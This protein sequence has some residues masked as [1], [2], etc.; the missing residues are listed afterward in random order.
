M[1]TL[2]TTPV[3]YLL[4]DRLH[5]RL[6]GRKKAAAAAATA[7]RR[8]SPP[9]KRCRRPARGRAI[10]PVTSYWLMRGAWRLSDAGRRGGRVAGA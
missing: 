2:Y 3:I 6:G 7:M 10:L 5:R 4:L 9:H 1:L 8:P